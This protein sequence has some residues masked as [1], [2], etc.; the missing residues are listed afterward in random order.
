M[1]VL[2]IAQ[3]D[4]AG[5][6]LAAV[7]VPAV[8]AE[9]QADQKEVAVAERYPESLAA[10]GC[11]AQGLKK[12]R[13][14]VVVTV[15]ACSQGHR[16]GFRIAAVVVAK[17]HRIDH[18]SAAAI[19]AGCSGQGYRRDYLLA[20]E[21]AD[22]YLVQDCQIDHWKTEVASTRRTTHHLA[23]VARKTTLKSCQAVQQR[24]E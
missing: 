8:V 18:L 7:L 6:A 10:V 15:V 1:A 2:A 21:A 11:P 20:A 13:L 23:E 3:A 17:K 4:S 16:R 19:V 22:S 9:V 12:V 5:F 24:I 14:I